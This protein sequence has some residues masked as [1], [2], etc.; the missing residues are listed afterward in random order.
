MDS[1]TADSLLKFGNRLVELGGALPDRVFQRRALIFRRYVET[2]H[3]EKIANAQQRLG[4]T[5]RL[6]P[7]ARTADRH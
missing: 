6:E 3:L 2:A 4:L 5:D 7:L 1:A